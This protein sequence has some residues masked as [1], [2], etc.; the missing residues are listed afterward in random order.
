MYREGDGLGVRSFGNPP[1]CGNIDHC[2]SKAFLDAEIPAASGVSNA[3]ALA[4]IY[5]ALARGGEI[6]GVR[7]LSP[8]TVEEAG[9]PWVSGPDAAMVLPTAFGL[10]FEVSIPEFWFGPGPRTYGHNGSG[11]SLGIVDPHAGI[12]LGYVMNQMVWGTSRTDPRWKPI[13]DALY[14]AL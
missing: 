3:R 4:R 14:S 11:G 13:F 6:D 8:E 7:L 10:G 9:K 2:N 1:D 12:G 5:G